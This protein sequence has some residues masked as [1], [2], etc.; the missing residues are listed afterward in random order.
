[1]P[2]LDKENFVHVNDLPFIRADSDIWDYAF[3]NRLDQN[4]NVKKNIF[5]RFVES[6]YNE[7]EEMLLYSSFVIV[8]ED[9]IEGF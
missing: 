8:N 4:W 9:K 2:F 7:V 6:I 1:M 3:Q 5:F